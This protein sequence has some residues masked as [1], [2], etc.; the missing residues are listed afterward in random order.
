MAEKIKF[1]ETE[2]ESVLRKYTNEN[3]FQEYIK[4]PELMKALASGYRSPLLEF[5][6]SVNVALVDYIENRKE[7]NLPM[8]IASVMEGRDPEDADRLKRVLLALEAG[9]DPSKY[10][11]KIRLKLGDPDAA[12]QRP[13]LGELAFP[14]KELTIVPEIKLGNTTLSFTDSQISE[15][16]TTGRLNSL[17]DGADS[18][19]ELQRFFVSVDKDLKT[20]RFLHQ[21]KVSL[22]KYIYGISLDDSARSQMMEGRIADIQIKAKG[23]VKTVKAYFDPADY[24]LKFV[25]ETPG[26][27]L[28]TDESQAQIEQVNRE[29]KEAKQK[30]KTSKTLKEVQNSTAAQKKPGQKQ[31]QKL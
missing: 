26:Q 7:Q 21:D 19:G 16:K 11:A 4:N 13:I 3:Q 17:V 30:T 9:E 15:L 18:N 8:D 31:G 1:S 28:R 12:G 29:A 6:S 5:T 20:L 2:I 25:S 10:T 27:I 23:E 14:R 22:P 24:K